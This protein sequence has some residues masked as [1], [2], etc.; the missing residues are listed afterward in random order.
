M[1]SVFSLIKLKDNV[2]LDPDQFTFDPSDKIISIL[3]KNVEKKI[4]GR[5]NGYILLISDVKSISQGFINNIS[6]GVSYSV[7][8][9]AV[10]FKPIKDSIIKINVTNYNEL[11]IWGIVDKISN[12]NIQCVCHKQMIPDKFHYDGEKDI[13]TTKKSN[14]LYGNLTTIKENSKVDFQIIDSKIDANKI[15]IIGKIIV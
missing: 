9:D 7:D 10:I 14:S 6:G 3:R 8:Y 5:E 12:T 4:I 11:G 15:L 1:N 2:K 13:W